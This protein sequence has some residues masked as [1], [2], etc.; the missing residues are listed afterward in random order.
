VPRR[1][2]TSHRLPHVSG[3]KGTARRCASGL[4]RRS[5]E[6][7]EAGPGDRFYAARSPCAYRIGVRLTVSGRRHTVSRSYQS[8]LLVGYRWAASMT[9]CSVRAA[10]VGGHAWV[11]QFGS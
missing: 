5:G 8:L 2:R 6:A 4:P 1:V 10:Y 9:L 7:A 11:I 3:G